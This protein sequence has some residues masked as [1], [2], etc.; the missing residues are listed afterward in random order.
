MKEVFLDPDCLF[1]V[2]GQ[3]KLLFESLGILEGFKYTAN[4]IRYLEILIHLMQIKL[5]HS[6]LTQLQVTGLEMADYLKL[7]PGASGRK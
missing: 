5:L 4:S 1:C 2:L 6:G 3:Q 7:N